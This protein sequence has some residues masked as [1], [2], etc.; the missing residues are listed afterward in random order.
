MKKCEK[1]GMENADGV[2][3]CGKCGNLLEQVEAVTT[4]PAPQP[5]PEVQ[6]I[7]PTPPMGNY[8]QTETKKPISIIGWMGY[9]LVFCIPIVNIIVMIVKLFTS[10]NKTFKNY[11]WATLIWTVI[12]IIL[13]IILRSVLAAYFTDLFGNLSM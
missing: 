8:Y 9:L 12:L 1:C 13:G 3:F 2:K 11:V 10:K 4:N 6:I 7:P 5:Q